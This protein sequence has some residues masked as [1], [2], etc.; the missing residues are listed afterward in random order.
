MTIIKVETKLLG[1]LWNKCDDIYA[2]ETE[3]EELGTVTIE[4][5]IENTSRYL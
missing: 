3:E 4:V 1:I 5:N 2:V